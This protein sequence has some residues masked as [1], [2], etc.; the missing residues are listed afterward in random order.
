MGPFLP[1]SDD[2]TIAEAFPDAHKLLVAKRLEEWGINVEKI[3]IRSSGPEAA[4]M[5]TVPEGV[6]YVHL[7][8]LKRVYPK[9]QEQ[10]LAL[11]HE[12]AHLLQFIEGR[13]DWERATQWGTLH[14]WASLEHEQ[15]AIR[16]QAREA[17]RMSISRQEFEK[18][19]HRSLPSISRELVLETR[20]VFSGQYPEER[21]VRP[22]FRRPVAVRQYRRRR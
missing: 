7:P 19:I 13:V 17:K 15:D 11:A 16:W 12:L 1:R 21:G 8:T 2:V 4:V 10:Y 6:I 5:A 9:P 18:M 22:M 14:E 20:P 3:L